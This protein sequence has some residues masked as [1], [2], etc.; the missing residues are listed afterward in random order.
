MLDNATSANDETQFPMTETLHESLEDTMLSSPAVAPAN[1]TATTTPHGRFPSALEET[2][3]ADEDDDEDTS[4]VMSQE[5]IP[6][7]QA[8]VPP[9]ATAAVTVGPLLQST[10]APTPTMSPHVVNTSPD[11][12]DM[13]HTIPLDFEPFSRTTS[14]AT[15][16]MTTATTTVEPVAYFVTAVCN[17]PT[18]VDAFEAALAQGKMVI[19][20]KSGRLCLLYIHT[21]MLGLCYRLDLR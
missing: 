4:H 14:L 6:L 1:V 15:L 2:L 18:H 19:E 7:S 17:Q 10:V 16:P 9:L 20:G 3:V 21:Y 13:P 12:A 8:M 5:L 11:R